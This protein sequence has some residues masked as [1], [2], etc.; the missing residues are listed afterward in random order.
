MD[1]RSPKEST[2]GAAGLV[3]GVCRLLHAQGFCLLTEFRLSTGHRA[4]VIG[5][6]KAGRFAI[7]E[8]KSCLADFRA[9]AKWHAYAPFADWFYFAVGGD[10]PTHVL[11]LGTGLIIADAFHAVITR[12]APET[13]LHASRRRAQIQRFARAAALRLHRLEDPAL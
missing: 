7:V 5:L 9:D 4:D 11:P 6:D 2:S 12:P 8:V 13:P 3:R 10:F 1:A